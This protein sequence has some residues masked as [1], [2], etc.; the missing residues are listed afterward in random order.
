MSEEN[1]EIVRRIYA[2]WTDGSPAESGLLN[3]EIEWINPHDAVETRVRSGRDAFDTAAQKVGT[4]SRSSA[5][6]LIRDGKA[7]R[8]EW[9][10]SPDQALE[11]AGV[12]A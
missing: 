7:I 5:W 6:T 3:A 4:P 11:A 10:S 12:E 2:A 9:F 8:F 1:V